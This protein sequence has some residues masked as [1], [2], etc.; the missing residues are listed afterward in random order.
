MSILPIIFGLSGAAFAAYSYY[1]SDEQLWRSIPDFIEDTEKEID[2]IQKSISIELDKIK[3]LP[4][5]IKEDI[6]S[7]SEKLR[8]LP[9]FILNKL[10]EERNDIFE[11]KAQ[12]GNLELE[13]ALLDENLKELDERLNETLYKLIPDKISTFTEEW[14]E[15]ILK[16]SSPQ[17]G[18]QSGSSTNTE[19][20]PEYNQNPT[21]MGIILTE[22]EPK[23]KPK[24]EPEPN[25]LITAIKKEIDNILTATIIDARDIELEKMQ[26]LYEKNNDP[27]LKQKI[28]DKLN[29]DISD[30]EV[31]AKEETMLM[32]DIIDDE[33]KE[34]DRAEYEKTILY[35]KIIATEEA[36]ISEF[37]KGLIISDL[38][39]K[40]K[41]IDKKIDKKVDSIIDA[42]SNFETDL[43]DTIDSVLDDSINLP[44][45]TQAPVPV[46]TQAPVPVTTQAPVPVTTQAPVP[47]TTQA[48]V[49]VT[50]Q[51][52]VPV[53]ETS[54]IITIPQ[55][56]PPDMSWSN[57]WQ[58]GGG[59]YNQDPY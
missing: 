7:D 46:T 1:T 41:E 48:P 59:V 58:E 30:V 29:Q 31:I 52:P 13:A 28:I 6:I 25:L 38:K 27:E 4:S 54:S 19:K 17:Q 40:I 16:W 43:Q 22:P 9:E 20:I 39:Q 51:A 56:S 34:L 24:P 8:R 35:N 37:E 33:S 12:G 10:I 42:V 49:P 45:T 21:E 26:I 47:V 3:D 2:S 23:P 32:K 18:P 36:D 50:T 14:K 11:L 55:D 57:Y 44:V 53:P 5:N 15:I